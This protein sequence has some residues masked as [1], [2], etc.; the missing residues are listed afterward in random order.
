MSRFT[1]L[2]AAAIVGGALAAAGTASAQD[3]PHGGPGPWAG[4]SIDFA[5]IDTDGDGTLSRE[6]LRAFALAR[7]GAADT[8]DDGM[9]ERAELVVLVPDHG[10]GF[11]RPFAQPRGE[12]F[13][14]RM[15]E[16]MEATE[17]GMVAVED[18][19]ERHVNALLARLDRNRDGAISQAEAEAR[20]Q[21][22]GP[23]GRGERGMRRGG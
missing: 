13:A 19:V 6:E 4:P 5:A 15:L 9:L 1:I 18:V 23:Q 21:R 12:R 16:R 10:G 22:R 14:D 7:V 8:S 2:S 17:A 20:P 11:F 3:R